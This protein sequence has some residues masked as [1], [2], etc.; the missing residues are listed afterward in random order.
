L[1]L[2]KAAQPPAIETDDPQQEAI[3]MSIRTTVLASL[4]A[5]VTAAATAPAAAQGG[6]WKCSAPG[7]V[8]A[9]YQG[10]GSA[11]IHLSGFSSGGTYPVTRKGKVATGVT[12]NGTRFTCRLS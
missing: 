11:Y 5:V 4:L 6:T 12:A 1:S 9:S 8:S 2:L 7:L 3:A 10:G